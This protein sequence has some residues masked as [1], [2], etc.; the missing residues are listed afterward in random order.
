M[1]ILQAGVAKSGNYWLWRIIAELLSEAGI[2]RKNFVA[3]QPIYE[4]IKNNTELSH[5]DQAELD[6]LDIV[7]NRFYW[8]VANIHRE[9]IPDINAYI[10]QSTHLWTHSHWASGCDR[11]LT[12]VDKTIYIIRDPRDVVISMANFAFTPYI[13]RH[14]PHKEHSAEEYLDNRMD[15]QIRNWIQHVSGWLANAQDRLHIVFFE[16]LKAQLPAELEALSRY[17]QLS[18]DDQALSRVAEAVSVQSMKTRGPNHVRQGKSG[19]WR[20]SMTSAQVARASTSAD[21][22]LDILG[23]ATDAESESQPRSP[24]SARNK[25]TEIYEQSLYGGRDLIRGALALMRSRRTLADKL[26]VIQRQLTS[27]RER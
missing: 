25:L 1:H 5:A 16:N 20:D 19:G 3:Q 9:Q 15:W 7:Q 18:L 27:M 22:L 12:A 26:R 21:Q 17:L 2:P 6:V 24:E 13:Q 8:R 10:D 11:L 14:A 4:Q 23:Y